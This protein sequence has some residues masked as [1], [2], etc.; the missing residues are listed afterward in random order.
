[1]RREE[2]LELREKIEARYKRDIEALERVWI[3]AN[4][5]S[6][7][8]ASPE[9]IREVVEQAATTPEQ[10]SETAS[11]DQNRE[12]RRFSLRREIEAL[13][14]EFAPDE[15]ITQGEVRRRLGQRFPGYEDFMKS[16]SVSSA[17]RRIAQS[18][19]LVLV[20]VGSGSEPNRYRRSSGIENAN[21]RDDREETLLRSGP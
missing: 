4:E 19:D 15:D 21:E 11:N 7:S 14:P 6:E 20:S 2:Y 9:T 1:M 10:E 16:A 8:K 13:L 17:L 5:H 18:D 12:V 3:I